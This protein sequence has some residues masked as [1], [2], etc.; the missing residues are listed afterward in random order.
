MYYKVEYCQGLFS[1]GTA[2]IK[3]PSKNHAKG[4]CKRKRCQADFRLDTLK[5]ISKAEY[6]RARK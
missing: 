5:R 4:Q 2:Y 6:D 1:G 3:A